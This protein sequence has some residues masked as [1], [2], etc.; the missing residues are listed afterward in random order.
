MAFDFDN[1]HKLE[2]IDVSSSSYV[3]LATYAEWGTDSLEIKGAWKTTGVNQM[4]LSFGGTEARAG[5]LYSYNSTSKITFY[6]F[7]DSKSQY[8]LN[9][10]SS[11]EGTSVH[12]YVLD[13]KN[14]IGST[15][16]TSNSMNSS[17]SSSGN[18]GYK[19][20]LFSGGGA[21]YSN[22][23]YFIGRF[24]YFAQYRNEVLLSKV[25]P[26]KRK[27]D[28]IIGLYDEVNRVFYTNAGSGSFTEGG[29]L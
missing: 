10:C 6:Y 27:S 21:S 26:A 22:S 25:V 14:K 13:L 3:E 8:G 20:K 16:G 4:I 17:S 7:N 19:I 18:C 12:T 11:A 5:W 15:D 9:M 23:Y 2:Y 1:Y 28:N 24:F 29:G